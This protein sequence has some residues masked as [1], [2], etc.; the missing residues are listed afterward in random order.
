[1][2]IKGEGGDMIHMIPCDGRAIDW[3]NYTKPSDY[4]QDTDVVPNFP[5]QYD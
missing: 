4:P 1:M 5:G 2:I 3:T